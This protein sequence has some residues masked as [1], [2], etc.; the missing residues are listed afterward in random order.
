[1]WFLRPTTWEQVGWR[2]MANA[3]FDRSFDLHSA[4]LMAGAKI[5]FDRGAWDP[6]AGLKVNE[7][8]GAVPGATRSAFNNIWPNREHYVSDLAAS[9]LDFLKAGVRENIRRNMAD[10]VELARALRPFDE[11]LTEAIGPTIE[12]VAEGRGTL[13]HFLIMQT[14]PDDEA[15]RSTVDEI[16]A[17]AFDE[18]DALLELLF[19]VYRRRPV[20]G[21]ALRDVS[22]AMSALVEGFAIRRGI[23]ADPAEL[24]TAEK[25]SIVAIVH[26]M[27][28]EIAEPFD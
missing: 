14:W 28:E 24:E 8:V 19:A 6:T 23:H 4:F 9:T 20:E 1:M 10:A 11:L 27:T 12:S 22:I 16:V 5:V 21:V 18:T 3:G 25:A 26:G 15:M 7:V 17:G 13:L 2:L